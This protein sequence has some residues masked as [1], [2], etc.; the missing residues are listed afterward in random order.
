MQFDAKKKPNS[1][2]LKILLLIYVRRPFI[3]NQSKN[4]IEK[5]T[6]T[7]HSMGIRVL[8]WKW[9]QIRKKWTEYCSSPMMERAV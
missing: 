5:R 1:E 7:E 6:K 3:Y 8:K 9:N 4:T 2:H